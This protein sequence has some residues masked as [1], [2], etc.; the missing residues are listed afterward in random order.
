MV[1]GEK[2]IQCNIRDSSERKEYENSLIQNIDQK[3]E[4]L[5]ELQHRIKNS[6]NL[7]TSLIFLKSNTI[8]SKAAKKILEELTYRVRSISDLY[9]L[10]YETQSIYEVDLKL[11]C[12]Q[13]IESM[14]S[15]SQN[16]TVTKSVEKI[17]ISPDNASVMGMILVKLISN[18]IKYAFNKM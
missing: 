4:M 8:K 18:A 14:I 16:I 7:I 11:Y 13:I 2:V 12:D 6:F 5:R 9:T 10:L 1:E 17:L 15:V 3:N